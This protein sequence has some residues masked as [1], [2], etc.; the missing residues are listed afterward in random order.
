MA[1]SIQTDASK[2]QFDELCRQW[3]KDEEPRLSIQFLP[4]PDNHIL[5]RYHGVDER[6]V[7]YASARNFP[8]AVVD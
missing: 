2:Y 3:H 8:L 4:T 5:G 6:I 1:C 7:A